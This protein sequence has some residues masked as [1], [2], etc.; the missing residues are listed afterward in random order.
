MTML[1]VEAK[2]DRNEVILCLRVE[3]L[4]HVNKSMKGQS[5]TIMSYYITISYHIIILYNDVS[6]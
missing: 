6:Y 5:A 4:R 1:I 3:L 2:V